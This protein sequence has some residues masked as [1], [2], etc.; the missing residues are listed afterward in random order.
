[1]EH[2]SLTSDRCQLALEAVDRNLDERGIEHNCH[3]YSRASF[4]N[5]FGIPL[6][7]SWLR[8]LWVASPGQPEPVLP[9]AWQDWEFWQFGQREIAGIDGLVDVDYFNGTRDELYAKYGK[10]PQP[11]MKIQ[12][13][14]AGNKVSDDEFYAVF[15][16]GYQPYTA[17]GDGTND[18]FPDILKAQ[19]HYLVQ[20]D[21]MALECHLQMLDG[22]VPADIEQYEFVIWIH[23]NDYRADFELKEDKAVATWIM[24]HDGWWYNPQDGSAGAA[25]VFVGR[26]DGELHSEQ[27]RGVGWF[28]DAVYGSHCH[29]NFVFTIEPANGP[30]PTQDYYLYYS[31]EPEEAGY[32]IAVPEP[33]DNQLPEDTMVT[34]TAYANE[35]WKF[36]CWKIGEEVL[37]TEVAIHFRLE[38]DM[39][40]DAHFVEDTG[41]IDVPAAIDDGFEAL[42]HNDA[43]REAIK[44]GLRNLG[45]NI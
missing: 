10:E 25:I 20:V 15:G 12:Y 27:V 34:L 2:S 43:E 24:G 9:D 39:A 7:W 8:Y 11:D 18:D 44:S 29:A 16:N 32:V 3:V 33:V 30:P 37:S 23:G 41:E 42:E 6:P 21:N 38:S 13:Y 4:L 45:V 1:M 35:G 5:P 14:L 17:V 36:S 22:S 28:S 40:I 19:I 31:A 26:K